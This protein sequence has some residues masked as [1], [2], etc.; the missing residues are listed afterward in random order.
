MLEKAIS[1]PF[2]YAP[3]RGSKIHSSQLKNSPPWHF[4]CSPVF[5]M[6]WFR[7]FEYSHILVK[8]AKIPIATF[9]GLIAAQ[10]FLPVAQFPPR[11]AVVAG[12][13]LDLLLIISAYATLHIA[14]Q[15]GRDFLYHSFDISL[16]DNIRQRRT[17]TQVDFVYRLTL[18]LLAFVSTAAFLMT[19]ESAR[20]V[21]AS[22]IASA[23]VAGILIGFAAQR[24]LSNLIAGFQIAFTQ[25]IRIDDVVVVEKEWG[26]V[27][28]ITL[29][30]VVIKL[31]D[32]RRLILPL[33]YFIEKPFEN[34]TRTSADILSSFFVY[35][36]HETPIERV[37]E[38][39]KSAAESS[40]LWDKKVCIVQ[41]TDFREHCIQL[42]VLVSARNGSDAFDLSC[43]LREKIL[44]GLPEVF[45]SSIPMSRVLIKSER[46]ETSG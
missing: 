3:S 13:L 40:P 23:G 18:I 16:A 10:L 28:E 31:W 35:L 12:H 36:D 4:A 2:F 39:A 44:T 25:P 37:R 9:V 42:R 33:N 8:R 26:R 19:F 1:M 34:W 30:Y 5:G 15:V 29:T 45:P 14:A 38:C 7:P 20:K 17:R 41:L 21:G 32:L 43:I 27:E 24:S 22:L 6:S 46:L 11:L